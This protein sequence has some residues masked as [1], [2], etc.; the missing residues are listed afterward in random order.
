MEGPTQVREEQIQYQLSKY[1]TN[2]QYSNNN[3]NKT[4][5]LHAS[6]MT[7]RMPVPFIQVVPYEYT[8]MP[9]LFVRYNAFL[10]LVIGTPGTYR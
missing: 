6:I 2:D 7:Y 9:I 3:K 1:R 10:F 4:S 8:A 5:T